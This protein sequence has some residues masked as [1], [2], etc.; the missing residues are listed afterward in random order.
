MP[1]DEIEARVKAL[2]D[3]H[4]KENAESMA[5]GG[6]QRYSPRYTEIK[7]AEIRSQKYEPVDTPDKLTKA[8]AN[9]FDF[10]AMEKTLGRKLSPADREKLRDDIFNELKSAGSVTKA[11]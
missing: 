2:H 1:A 9:A 10:D 5:K 3:E 6:Y 4:A 11:I 7:E 8:F